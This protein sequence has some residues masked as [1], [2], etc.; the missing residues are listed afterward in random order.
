MAQ[1][2]SAAIAGIHAAGIYA[3]AERL[4]VQPP[5]TR[6]WIPLQGG[7]CVPR[8]IRDARR[9]QAS[10]VRCGPSL[11]Y[12][13][14]IISDDLQMVAPN[15]EFPPPS[16]AVHFLASGGDMVTVSHDIAVADATYDAIYAA[17]LNGTYPRAQLDASV[18]KLMNLGLRCH[19][20]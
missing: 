20:P 11:G 17:V 4:S 18:Q 1:D 9:H 14:V 8:G 6:D 13:G 5:Q 12:Q 2:V 16:A 19:M 7:D 10:Y 3:V 15:P